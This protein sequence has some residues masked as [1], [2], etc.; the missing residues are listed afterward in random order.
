MSER[1]Y[2]PIEAPYVD[3][4]DA[5]ISTIED[6]EDDGCSKRVSVATTIHRY[7][8]I[9]LE[10]EFEK[11][12]CFFGI[13]IY[14]IK[15]NCLSEMVRYEVEC[16]IEVLETGEYNHL[17]TEEDWIEIKKDIE[18]LKPYIFVPEIKE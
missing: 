13:A 7:N 2:L 11:C 9:F 12:L 14:Q 10:N 1:Q 18:W 5:I 17:A 16:D 3:V 4:R 8:D 15:N 6:Y